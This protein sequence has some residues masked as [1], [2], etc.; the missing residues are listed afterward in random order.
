[1]TVLNHLSFLTWDN[2]LTSIF[3]LVSRKLLQT[4]TSTSFDDRGLVRWRNFLYHEQ[5]PIHVFPR[6]SNVVSNGIKYEW[7]KRRTM[8]LIRSCTSS[9]TFSLSSL[10]DVTKRLYRPLQLDTKPVG[11]ANH[12]S[13]LNIVVK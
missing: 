2:S 8:G 7:L 12:N 4:S 1:M 3:L 6:S 5:R 10:H 13:V 9:F 11:T